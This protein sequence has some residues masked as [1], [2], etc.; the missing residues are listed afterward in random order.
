MKLFDAFYEE[1]F[2]HDLYLLVGQ[3]NSFNLLEVE[4]H[5][6]RFWSW[7]PDIHFSLGLF[8][9]KFLSIQI[10]LWSFSLNFSLISYRAPMDFTYIRKVF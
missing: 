10:E 8:N 6:T 3:F 2:G 5:T 4:I 7:E 1:D 9:G